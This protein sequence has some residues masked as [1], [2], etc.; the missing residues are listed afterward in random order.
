MILLT[1]STGFVGNAVLLL[2]MQQPGVIVRTYGRSAPV[3]LPDNVVHNAGH[4]T[5]EISGDADYAAALHDIDVIIHC[6]AQAHINKD[7]ADNRAEFNKVNCDGTLKLAHQAVDAGIKRL[8]YISSIGV[9]GGKN[10]NGP[11]KYNDIAAPWDE[12]TQSKYAAEL[13]LQQLTKETGLEVV[14][15]RPPL[16]YGANAPGNFG[17]LTHAVRTGRWLP[18]GAIHNQRSFVALPNLVDLIMTCIDH[19]N[20]ANQTF[21]VSDDQDISTTQLLKIMAQAAGKSPRLVPV[22]MC[23][24]RLLGRVT[25]KQAMIERVCGNLQ[26]DISYTKQTLG[27]QPP[28]SVAEGIKRCFVEEE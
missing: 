13:G 21:L 4:I 12:Y 26:V 16:V 23:C 14:I 1:G 22:P 8:I 7:E 20:A 9:N 15:I 24:L 25:G 19:S 5:G 3:V 10:S 6:A 2:L 27:W 18:L 11:F 17:K 28:I